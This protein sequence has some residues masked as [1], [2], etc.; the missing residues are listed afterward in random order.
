VKPVTCGEATNRSTCRAFRGDRGER[1]RKD[2][3]RN[4]GDPVW[5]W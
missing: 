1:A 4:L 5:W 3:L 2:V